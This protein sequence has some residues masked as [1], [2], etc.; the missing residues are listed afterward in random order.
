MTT[1]DYDDMKTLFSKRLTDIM[2]KRGNENQKELSQVLGVSEST[3]GKWLLKKAMPR[4][5][6]IQKIADHYGVGKSY[7]LEQ[8]P[9]AYEYILSNEERMLISDFRRLNEQG[10]EAAIGTVHAYT[11]MAIYAKKDMSGAGS[12]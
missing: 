9:V 2:E 8:N 12:I 6:V 5:G 7:F 4:M 3:V 11:L 10:Q 1:K